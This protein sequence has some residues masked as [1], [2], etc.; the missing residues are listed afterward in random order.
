MKIAFGMIVFN[1]DAVLKQCLEAI[2]P[3]AHKICIA[4]GPVKWWQDQGFD[5]S[6][7]GTI[8]IINNFPDH[9][10]K[11]AF[12]NNKYKDKHEQ[13]RAWFNMIPADTDYVW[14]VDADE[15][16][17]NIPKVIEFLEKENPTSVGFQSNTFFGGFDHILNGFEREHSFK[18]ILKY[19]RG[20]EYETHRPP[21]LSLNGKRIQGKDISGKELYQDTGVEMFHYSY[22]FP[23]MVQDKIRFYESAIIKQGQCIPNYFTDVWMKWVNGTSTDRKHIENRWQGVHE[24]HPASRGKCFPVEFNGEHPDIIKRD[25]IELKKVFDKQL[26]S[27]LL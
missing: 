11:I 8:D 27:V 18:R 1:T 17:E 24:F 3:Y 2:Y 4:E 26:K 12:I 9:E 21:S 10:D 20:C 19:E 16:H 25:M 5:H 6:T 7:D 13:C 15:I 14:C 23:Y 22:V